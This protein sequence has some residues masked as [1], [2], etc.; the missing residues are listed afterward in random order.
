MY[1]FQPQY[2]H[3]NSPDWSPYISLKN[4]LTEFGTISQHYLIL[5]TLI[6]FSLGNI[7][8]LLGENCCWALLGLKVVPPHATQTQV[9]VHEK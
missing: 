1:P 6:T 2:P 4:K 8:I 7:W 5:L 3:T 9:H